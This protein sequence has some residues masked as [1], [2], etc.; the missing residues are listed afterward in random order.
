[1]CV[2]EP[3]ALKRHPWKGHSRHPSAPTL[4]SD[5]FTPR[6][7]HWSLSA[8]SVPRP[9]R[10]R[11]MRSPASV[12]PSGLPRTSRD[13]AT[14]V[15]TSAMPSWANPSNIVPPAP[16]SPDRISRVVYLI[17]SRRRGRRTSRGEEGWIPYDIRLIQKAMARVKGSRNADYEK[18]RARL[19]EAARLRLLAPDGA[20]AS[21][22]ELAEAAEVSVATLR[23][24]FG[25][26]E[27]L[28]M[29]VMADMHRR[30]LPY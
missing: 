14:G 7:G 30:G 8:D 4:P 12:S 19:L 2:H 17:S 21:F 24:Y 6:C 1:M 26:R 23:H 5:S 28:V 29:E 11:A 27:T 18:E 10:N 15:H 20:Q 16:V 22:R 3:L 13:I 25:S 9:S